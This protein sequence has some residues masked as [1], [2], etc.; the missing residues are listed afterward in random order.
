METQDEAAELRI[1]VPTVPHFANKRRIIAAE[2][3][4]ANGADVLVL[5]DDSNID[6]SNVM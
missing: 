3:A 5:D 6:K 4:V 1:R 2:N